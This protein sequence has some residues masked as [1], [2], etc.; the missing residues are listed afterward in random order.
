[1]NQLS[2]STHTQIISAPRGLN[3]LGNLP[4]LEVLVDGNLDIIVYVTGL[5]PVELNYHSTKSRV[6]KIDLSEII[7]P[8]LSIDF[9]ATHQSKMVVPVLV[10]ISGTTFETL[11][12]SVLYAGVKEL[13]AQP[14]EEWIGRHPLSWRSATRY[15]TARQPERFSVYLKPSDRVT[16]TAYSTDSSEPIYSEPLAV[17]INQEGVYTIDVSW[18]TIHNRIT[19]F[20]EVDYYDV[21]SSQGAKVRYVLDAKRGEDETWFF[22]QSGLG[23]LDTLRATGEQEAHLSCEDVLDES[24]KVL[25]AREVKS[26]EHFRRYVGG[27]DKYERLSVSDFL[28]SP[29]RWVFR[30]GK[31]YPIVI[32]ESTNETSTSDE[33]QELAFDYSL[34][35]TLPF[36]ELSHRMEDVEEVTVRNHQGADFTLPRRSFELAEIEPSD[37]VVLPALHPGGEYWGAIS[38]KAI[39][40]RVMKKTV[41]SV[42]SLIKSSSDFSRELRDEINSGLTGALVFES[43]GRMLRK[44][45]DSCV[46]RAEI[47]TITGRDVT[48][49][50]VG[51]GLRINWVK[52]S[53]DAE[54]DAR[55]ADSHNA[56]NASLITITTDDVQS[57]AEIGFEFDHNEAKRIL[58]NYRYI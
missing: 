4:P 56:N 33:L 21:E 31:I 57:S 22:W 41:D 27:V 35:N 40:D 49:L 58:K 44:K 43:G 47:R 55:F 25:R 1:M 38:Y 45:D 3:L 2:P 16:L 23:G 34:S 11:S 53:R 52:R 36:L 24:G 10:N 28:R 5:K 32:K 14:V 50:L 51:G 17:S 19:K 26:S 8:A 6:A 12:F 46:V 13:P 54:A 29:A 7:A 18:S 15:V 42:S 20:E 30:G 37:G 9:F 48:T 39:E